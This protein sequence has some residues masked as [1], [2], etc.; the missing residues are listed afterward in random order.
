MSGLVK[1]MTPCAAELL[2]V[3]GCGGFVDVSST[4]KMFLLEGK[5]NPVFE[6]YFFPSGLKALPTSRLVFHCFLS[7][8]P[9]HY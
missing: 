6:E 4:S 3:A 7:S 1:K 9:Y 2:L 5:M 8:I